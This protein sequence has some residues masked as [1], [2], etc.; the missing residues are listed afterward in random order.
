MDSSLNPQCLTELLNKINLGDDCARDKLFQIIYQD[1]RI[2]A[3]ARMKAIPPSE[4]LQPTALVNEMYLRMFE[5]DSNLK[6]ENRKHFFWA[7]ARAMHDILVEKARK[8]QSLKRGGDRAKVPLGDPPM[9]DNPDLEELLVLSEAISE[10]AKTAPRAAETVR[11]R[12]FAGLTHEQVAM[13]L[14]I[15][16]STA[17]R[18]WTYAKAWLHR[19]VELHKDKPS[20]E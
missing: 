20:T 3:H 17:R 11:L 4:T 16:T 13:T 14:D 6:W 19:Q 7:A 9:R 12:F 1:M 5:R 18:E 8:H 2:M 15:S 10:L